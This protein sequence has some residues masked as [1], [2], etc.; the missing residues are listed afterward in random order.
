MNNF[1][2]T[3]NNQ[4]QIISTIKIC[5]QCHYREQFCNCQVTERRESN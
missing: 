1:C 2:N 3:C 5:F 4:A